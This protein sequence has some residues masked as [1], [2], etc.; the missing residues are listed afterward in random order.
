MASISPVG[1]A[2][3]L[4][5]APDFGGDDGKTLAVFAGAG[6]FNGGIEGEQVGLR[7]DMADEA[8]RRCR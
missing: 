1:R 8:S 3:L 6:G 5:E 4:G 7:G 2:G